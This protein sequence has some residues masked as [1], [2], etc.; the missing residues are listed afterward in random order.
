MEYNSIEKEKFRNHSKLSDK[1]AGDV[2][3]YL[4]TLKSKDVAEGVIIDGKPNM[5]A[6]LSLIKAGLLW[7]S[8]CSEGREGCWRLKRTKLR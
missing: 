6:S 4:M 7:M 8:S 2:T 1:E 5:Q 3:A